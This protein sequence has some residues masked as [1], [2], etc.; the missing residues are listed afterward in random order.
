MA[1]SGYFGYFVGLGV[2]KPRNSWQ[3]LLIGYLSS[4]SLHALWNTSGFFSGLILAV[5]GV[6]S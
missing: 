3:I 4:A 1:Y 6:L 2:L 5:V